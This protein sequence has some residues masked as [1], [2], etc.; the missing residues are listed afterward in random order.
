LACR[1]LRAKTGQG[2]ALTAESF[3]HLFAS[4]GLAKGQP[5]A[6]VAELMGHSSTA[7]IS[8]YYGRLRDREDV[9]RG[10]RGRD[11]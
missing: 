1:R 3:R 6:T 11:P 4:D 9:A 5:I 2:A 7:M 8:R 10:R